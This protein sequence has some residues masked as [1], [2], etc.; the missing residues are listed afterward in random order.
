MSISWHLY[1]IHFLSLFIATLQ[2]LVM[3]IEKFTDRMPTPSVS[4][5]YHEETTSLVLFNANMQKP[6]GG[7]IL[8]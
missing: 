5:G 8:W 6:Q 7:R 4:N 1:T 3:A 2:L